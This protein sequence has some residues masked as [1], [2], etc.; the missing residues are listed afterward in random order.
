MNDWMP[1]AKEY[2][3]LKAG[4]IDGTDED[5]HDRAVWRAMLARYVP[6][7]GVTGDPLLTL[8]VARLN[9][10]TKEDKLREVFSRYGDIRRLRLVRDLVTGFSKGYAFIEF[11]EE[12]AL[13]KAYRDADGL[14]VD[15]RE[16]FVDYELE[17]TLRGWVPR[18]LGGGLG[19]KKESGQLRFGGRDR[20]FRKPIN[21]PVVKGDLYREGKRDRRERSRSRERHWESRARERDHDRGREK[22]WPER[23]PSRAWPENDWE[24]DPREDRPRGREKRDRSK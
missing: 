24:R 23:E 9:L 17:R 13:L 19:G 21:L 2:D 18:R 20:P 12:R 11:R 10:Q 22:R 6:N 1:I 4:S 15:Q 14:L 3:P 7:K 16:L 8:F 5:P